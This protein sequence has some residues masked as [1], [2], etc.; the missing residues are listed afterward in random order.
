MIRSEYERR[1]AE[2]SDIFAHLPRL[3]SEA[4]RPEVKVIELGVRAG[5]STAAF[6]LAAEENDGFVWSVDIH[7]PRVPWFGIERWQFIQGD[8]LWIF[9]QLPD[10]VDVLFIDTSHHYEQTVGEL[11]LYVPKVRPG[12][13]V[14]LH[15][16]ELETPEGHP[17]GDPAFPVRVAVQEYCTEHDIA[18]LFVPGC[19]GLGVIHVP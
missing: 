12:G 10:E 8:D 17:P 6:L 19:N 2:P 3:Y 18:P 14:L 1:C 13:V 7:P 11:E 5:N 15:D 4:S 9:D 16:T